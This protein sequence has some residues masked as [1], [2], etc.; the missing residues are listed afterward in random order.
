VTDA[1]ASPR[2]E[3]G[4]NWERFVAVITPERVRV[5]EDSL[6]QMLGVSSLAGVRF[7]DLG[8]GSGLFSLSARRL[9][10]EVVSF[11]YDPMSVACTEELK[12]RHFP[13]DPKWTVTRGSVL[14]AQFMSGL[15]RF[16]IVYSWGV[17]HHTGEM[18]RAIDQAVQRVAPGGRL[19]IA[20]YNDQ[21]AQSVFWTH[22]KKTYNRLPQVLRYPYLLAF[23]TA[24]EI[25]AA[26]S[27]LAQ[28]RP[29]RLVQ[30]WT[31]YESVRGM[32]R[33]HDIVDWVGGY[34]FEVAKPEAVFEFCRE[35]GL[36]LTTLRTCGGRMGCNEFVFARED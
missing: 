10:A 14:D 4:A 34:P 31:R 32:S 22:V 16:D 12:R 9:G 30:R 1:A 21:G 35:R 6:R 23:G 25:A 17:L 36:R 5:A 26:G 13:D 24:L 18:W 33:W 20:I 7:L 11:D 8:S 29:G 28:L 27:A 19:F 15:G 2:F 3:F